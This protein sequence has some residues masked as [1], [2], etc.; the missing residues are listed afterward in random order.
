MARNLEFDEDTALTAVMHAFRKEGYHRSSIKTLERTTGLSSGSLYNS[1][2]GKNALF[3]RAFAHYNETVVKGRLAAH[4]AG[5]PARE[6]LTDLFVSLLD[7]PDG[8]QSGCLIT[9][10]AIEFAGGACPAEEDLQQGVALLQDAF[11]ES[12]ATLPGARARVATFCA[13]RLLI[14]YQGLLVMIRGGMA[15]TNLRQIIEAEI[16]SIL[17]DIDA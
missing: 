17:G 9:N 3:R 7:E 15:A 11:E 2:G 12:L 10:S 6:G 13:M 4:L 1:F 8:G 5:R 16:D 14:F